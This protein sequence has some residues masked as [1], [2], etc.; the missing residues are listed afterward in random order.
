LFV[1]HVLLLFSSLQDQLYV[2]IEL[3]MGE[4]KGNSVL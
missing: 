1:T 3:C 4:I 2:F